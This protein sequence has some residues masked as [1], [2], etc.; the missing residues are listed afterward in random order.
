M[1]LRL[2]GHR[3]ELAPLALQAGLGLLIAL[4]RTGDHAAQLRKLVG[5]ADAEHLTEV[6]R[7]QNGLTRVLAN[8][9]L[10]SPAAAHGFILDPPPDPDS[11]LASP[12]PPPAGFGPA[13]APAAR[14]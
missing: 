3:P 9:P 7:K 14:R 1:S 6:E 13:S 8:H 11:G 2:D 10:R 12:I 5:G 4:G